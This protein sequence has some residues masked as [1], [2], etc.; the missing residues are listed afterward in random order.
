MEKT[1][2]N[3]GLN[4]NEITVYLI[5]L[6]E[7]KLK[8]KELTK[9]TSLSRGLVYKALQDLED[10]QIIIREDEE[11]AVSEF[12]AIHPN[13]LGGLINQKIE[14]LEMT[15]KNLSNEMGVFTSLYN[16]ANNKP[17]VEF[18]EGIEGMQKMYNEIL[19]NVKTTK[20]IYSFVKVM[21]SKID[22]D[23]ARMLKGYI[24]KRTTRKIKT[25]VIA[26]ESDEARAL[27]KTDK[28]YLRTT[29]LVPIN[30]LPLEFYGGEIIIAGTSVYFMSYEKESYVA[31][32]VSSK[33]MSQ[34]L[35]FIF[36]SLWK[37]Y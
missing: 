9:K 11:N 20:E 14:A 1:L 33:S 22:K 31:V 17:G 3:L 23:T 25:R 37:K 12:S 6:R 7:G 34:M 27:Q 10:K 21:N 18:Y 28:D 29:K 15:K 8:A 5:L 13:V 24:E 26:I 4:E 32:A 30:S 36:N 2:Q 16:L 35:M 19:L